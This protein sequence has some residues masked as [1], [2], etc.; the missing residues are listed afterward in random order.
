V[1]IKGP[2]T[3]HLRILREVGVVDRLADPKHVFT[4]LDA[5]IAHARTHVERRHLPDRQ[6]SNEFVAG[7]AAAADPSH[8]VAHESQ[9]GADDVVR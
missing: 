7:V 1:L 4:D 6:G 2:R 8:D 9:R 5:A 3:H